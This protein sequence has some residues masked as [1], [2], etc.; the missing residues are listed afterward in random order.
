MM[1]AIAG[2]E[3]NDIH[4]TTADHSSNCAMRIGL[5]MN[6]SAQNAKDNNPATGAPCHAKTAA[7]G[8]RNG[9]SIIAGVNGAAESKATTSESVTITQP[10]IRFRILLI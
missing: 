6:A 4:A 9:T 1:P 3:A 2:T 8:N 10:K 7:A 5:N